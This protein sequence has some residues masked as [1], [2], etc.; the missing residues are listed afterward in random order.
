MNCAA[1]DFPDLQ[2]LIAQ[3]SLLFLL[4]LAPL[5]FGIRCSTRK[6]SSQ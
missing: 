2:I 6:Q 4:L 5:A 1:A 3:G